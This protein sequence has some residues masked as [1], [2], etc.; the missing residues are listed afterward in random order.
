METDRTSKPAI[1][2]TKG[3]VEKLPV[4][5]TG[6]EIYRDIELKGFGIRVTSGGTKTYVGERRI[7][8][9]VRRV[10]L[11]RSN[12]LSAEEA[13]RRAQEFLGKVAGGRDPIAEKHASAARDITL[14]KVL[15]TY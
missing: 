1:K 3:A 15:E 8:G 10:T 4:P 5:E 14:L 6:Q 9:K 11:G 13:R 2:L 7:S 12:V